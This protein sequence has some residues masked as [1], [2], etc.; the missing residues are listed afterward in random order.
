MYSI[1]I[2]LGCPIPVWP[3]GL[4]M[5]LTEIVPELAIKASA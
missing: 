1:Y 3:F 4:V 2:K 5:V